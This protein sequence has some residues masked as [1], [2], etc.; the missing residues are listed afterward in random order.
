MSKSTQQV[1][2]VSAAPKAGPKTK[3]A[4]RAATKA[5]KVRAAVATSQAATVSTI[6]KRISRTTKWRSGNTKATPQVRDTSKL[7][8]VIA[9]LRRKEGATIEQLV[10][11][12]DWQ[13]HSVRGAISGAIKKKL[14]LNV[15]SVKADDRR[16]YRIAG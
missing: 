6:S 5:R 11:A 8:A 16:V 7:A 4:P 1:K 13:A 9:M 10:K 15:E 3:N 14:G 2:P 12:T